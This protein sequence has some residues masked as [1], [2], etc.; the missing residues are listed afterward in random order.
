MAGGYVLK[1]IT[2]LVIEQNGLMLTVLR[3]ILR[4]LGIKNVR[5]AKTF[6]DAYETLRETHAD[7]VFTDWSPNLDAIRFIRRLRRAPD[8]PNPFLPVIVLTAFNEI[9]HVRAARDAGMTEFLAKPVSAKMIYSRIV[10]VIE[11]SR[12]FVRSADFFGPDRRRRRPAA[13]QGADR[14]TKDE[15]VWE[16]GEP[17][18]RVERTTR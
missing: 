1:D 7:V 14:R 2:V 15:E 17:D 10:A 13:Y 16:I 9:R 3:G 11:K 12:V 8:S 6:N 5:F 4:E 18:E